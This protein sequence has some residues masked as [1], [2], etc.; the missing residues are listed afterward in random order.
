M[1]A[2]DAFVE[3]LVPRK[4]TGKHMAMRIGAIVGGIVLG[5]GVYLLGNVLAFQFGFAPLMMIGFLLGA[6]V[7][8]LFFRLFLS[9][10]VE[11]E[12]I[13]TNGEMDVDKIINRARRK[14]LL[15][16]NCKEFEALAKVKDPAHQA[17]F[18]S[19]SIKTRLDVSSGVVGDNTY[20]AI[21]QH[22]DFGRTLLVFEPSEKMLR[23]FRRYIPG[24]M[25]QQ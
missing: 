5:I 10:N 18:N 13:L 12:Y 11:H 7:I 14:R 1:E 3:Q 2:L 24:K 9:L 21:F 23:Q 17:E 6:G 20:F 8:Y 25:M 4:N 22:R 16:V 19:A 15:T